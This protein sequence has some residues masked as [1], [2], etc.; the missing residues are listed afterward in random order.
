MK[1]FLKQQLTLGDAIM[2]I[3]NLVPLWG[4]WFK[5]WDAK[6]LFVVYCFETIIAGLY[7]VIQLWL[8]TLVKKKDIWNEGDPDSMVSGYLFIVFFIVH[9]ELFV[10]I[11]MQ[12][13]MGIL[14][15]KPASINLFYFIIHVNRFIP[16][17]ALL[18]LL[19]FA[20]SYGFIVVKEFLLTGI[21]KTIDMGTLMFA[22]YGRIFIQQFVV[23]IG[24]FILLFNK[25]GEIFILLF[26][27]TKIFFGLLLDFKKIMTNA[28]EKRKKNN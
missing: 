13:F 10:F 27:I 21:Y 3:T 7:T 14:H 12:I 9:Y 8:T 15:V 22:P 19:L 28:V 4:V 23:I 5:G 6:M 25:G 20:V 16:E 24:S 18:M 11:Q 26:V 2:I 1:N 17:Y